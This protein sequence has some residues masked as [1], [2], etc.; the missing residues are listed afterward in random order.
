MSNNEWEQARAYVDQLRQKGRTDQ[1][2]R[3]IMLKGGWTEDQVEQLFARDVLRAPPPPPPAAPPPARTDAPHR[4]AAVPS[5][6]RRPRRPARAADISGG[7]KAGIILVSIFAPLAG[8]IWGVIYVFSGQAAKKR[9]GAWGLVI[10]V[11]VGPGHIALVFPVVGPMAGYGHSREQAKQA[12]CLSYMKQLGV[13]ALMYCYDYDDAGRM[14]DA[15]DW[16][17]QTYPYVK[18]IY[19]CPSGGTYAMN[20]ELSWKKLVEI[21]SPSKTVLFYEVD[22]NG[23]RLYDVHMGTANYTYVDGHVASREKPE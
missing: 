15:A 22:R 8:F 2:I 3:Q 12:V 5:A 9:W 18:K 11:L 17:E 23:N 6:G 19:H 7:A 14:P 21:P 16:Q 13:G 10:S 20:A 4:P 1:Q